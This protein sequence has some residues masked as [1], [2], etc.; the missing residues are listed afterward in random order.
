MHRT[1]ILLTEEQI[2]ALRRIAA[3]EGRS[4]ADVVREGVGEY[5]ARHRGAA[6]R[7]TRTRQ[8]LELAGRYR[9][10]EKDTARDHD[11]YLDEAYADRDE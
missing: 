4:M 10:G 11:R 3:E 2:R 9:S 6:E 5:L 1:Q 7:E 8:V